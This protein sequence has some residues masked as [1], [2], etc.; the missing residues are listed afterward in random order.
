[1]TLINSG[2]Q[3]FQ[4]IG[5]GRIWYS[6][7]Q[8][9]SYFSKLDPVELKKNNLLRQHVEDIR[10]ASVVALFMR[11]L[12]HYPKY[13]AFV[14]LFRPD[15]P[16][17][18]VML[19]SFPPQETLLGSKIEVTTYTGSPQE[20]LLTRLQRK[21]IK[22]GIKTFTPEYVLA[23]NLGIGFNI[24]QELKSIK[25]YAEEQ[26]V[27]FPIWIVQEIQSTP[28]TIAE[29]TIIDDTVKRTQVNIGELAFQYSDNKIPGVIETRR[30]GSQKSVRFEKT[31]ID[32]PPPWETIGK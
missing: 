16:D 15:P 3:S 22:P 29:I 30:A 32:Y 4:H 12:Y 31:D 10:V 23:V 21:K 25:D 20:T 24:D 14:Q 8:V 27:D 13:Y 2:E 26:K 5:C 6:P 11:T 9:F 1:M 17:A 19:T 28:D 7:P 18:A